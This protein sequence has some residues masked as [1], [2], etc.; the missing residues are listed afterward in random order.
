MGPNMKLK[1]DDIHTQKKQQK[2]REMMNAV[3]EVIKDIENDNPK[4]CECPICESGIEENYTEKFGFNLSRCRHCQL[5][6]CNPYPTDKQLFLYYTSEMKAFEN[7]FF[8][9]SFEQRVN[10]FLPRVELIQRFARGGKLLDVGSAIG[11]FIE[12]LKRSGAPFDIACCDLNPEACS[13]LS[14][15]YPEIEVFNGDFL[16]MPETS[17]FGVITLW[18][19][20]EHIV[21][22]SALLKKVYGLLEDDGVFIFS[23]PNTRSFEWL[24]AGKEHV[25]L[26]PPGHVNLLNEASI[27]IL[28][29][30]HSF[31]VSETFTLNASLDISYVKKLIENGEVD[32]QR[33][34]LFLKEEIYDSDFENMLESYLVKHKKAG[35]IV[36]V[37]EKTR[38]QLA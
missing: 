21:D 4:L 12:A 26:L 31:Q 10:I 11:I 14:Q 18:D 16:Q 1:F 7:E 23:T 28:L 8:R 33:L 9:E 13:D 20:I 27:G 30:K 38:R 37:A 34:G 2:L 36:V 24:I 15:R 17:R 5:I 25:Q 6:F 19:T 35:N 22:L 32:V 3:T 29:G